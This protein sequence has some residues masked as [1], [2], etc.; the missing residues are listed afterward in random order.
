MITANIN[1]SPHFQFLLFFKEFSQNLS[2]RAQGYTLQVEGT[3]TMISVQAS[4][5]NPDSGEV[6]SYKTEVSKTFHQ[7]AP[8]ASNFRVSQYTKEAKEIII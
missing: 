2:S 8:V 6:A 7:E 3:H 1:V 5:N 4:T